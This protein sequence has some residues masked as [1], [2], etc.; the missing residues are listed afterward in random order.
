MNRKFFNG[1][2]L[3][4]LATGG[5][6]TFTSC[7]DH[8]QEFRNDVLKGQEDLSGQIAAIRNL[9]DG[10]FVTNLDNEIQKLIDAGKFASAADL[11]TLK[12]RVDGIDETLAHLD[13]TFATDKELE[14]AVKTLQNELTEALK[15]Y[16]TKAEVDE[17]LKDLSSEIQAVDDKATEA[18]AKAL[19]NEAAIAAIKS[20][21]ALIESRVGTLEGELADL[22]KDLD[23]FKDNVEQLFNRYARKL[24]NLVT[25]LIVE[26]TYNP[27][28]GTINLPMGLE[29][30]MLINYYFKPV[31]TVSFPDAAGGSEYAEN[32]VLKQHIFIPAASNKDAFDFSKTT[33]ETLGNLYMTINP[34][35][36]NNDGLTFQLVQSNG[37]ALPVDFTANSCDEVLTFGYT[38]GDEPTGFYKS[39]I[40]PEK[41]GDEAL[42]AATELTIDD[43]LKTAFKDAVKNHGKQDFFQLAKALYEQFDG[44]VPAYAAKVSWEEPVVS[45]V[46]VNTG[47]EIAA[48]TTETKSVISGY[49]LAA[50]SFRPLSYSTGFDLGTSRELPTFGSLQNAVNR[51]FDA[52]G[53]KLQLNLKIDDSNIGINVDDLTIEIG[54]TSIKINLGGMPVV[55]KDKLGKLELKDGKWL[56]EKGVDQTSHVVGILA[57][58]ANI[59][60][61][62]NPD[63]NT[64]S[65]LNATALNELIDTIIGSMND[66]LVGTDAKPGLAVELNKQL[67]DMVTD[68]NNQLGSVQAKIDNTVADIRKKVNDALAGRAGQAA[69]SLVNLY[70][71]FANKFNEVVKNPNAYLQVVAGYET[72]EGEMHHLSTVAND[73]TVMGEGVAKLFLTSYNAELIVPSY[74]KYVSINK[75]GATT[76]DE[77]LCTKAGEDFNKILNG[78]QQLVAL[79]TKALGKGDY[80]IFYQSLDFR[81]YTST[82]VYY[83]RVK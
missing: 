48:E 47:S 62:Y 24:A 28:F 20:D 25:G 37:D 22:K 1:L 80:Q 11:E 56:D 64:V 27:V 46:E 34:I 45:G 5:V 57:D 17:L 38:R 49:D 55:D 6:G 72:Q 83:I 66:K 79:D 42:I 75:V 36:R 61:G 76:A 14:D 74:K 15:D 70:N 65:D 71:R 69:Q 4:A 54:E 67:K 77:A 68:I 3:L 9:T 13:D 7:T 41:D 52:L 63:T 58:N 19:A 12:G 10:T 81:G 35:E 59:V 23:L 18:L 8:E 29:S 73:P 30:N 16:Y 44:I 32:S 40:A 78:R 43:N 31:K 53:N 60:L 51:A 50:A 39:E 82:K 26:R 2:L 21:L 33:L